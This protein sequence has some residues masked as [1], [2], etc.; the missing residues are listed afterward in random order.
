MNTS[1]DSDGKP[2]GG[3][4]RYSLTF[5]PGGLPKVNAFWSLTIYDAKHNLIE[6]PI[7]RYSIGDGTEGV[8]KSP[9]GSLTLYVQND[10]PGSDK[11]ANWL[12]APRGEFNL[13]LRCYAPTQEIID[14]TWAPPPL[15][16]GT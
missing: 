2:L 13:T 11:E 16:L 7:K 8:R 5:P 3:G 9:D 6:N 12:P 14:Q 1:T 10:S 4:S 15:K